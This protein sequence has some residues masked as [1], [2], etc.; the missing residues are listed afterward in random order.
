MGVNIRAA[1]GEIHIGNNTG[2]GANSVLIAANHRG[3]PN[4]DILL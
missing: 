4:Q 1:G 2:V 3:T